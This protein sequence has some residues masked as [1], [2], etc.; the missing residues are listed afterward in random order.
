MT[1]VSF[2]F[3]KKDKEK[4]ADIARA[5]KGIERGGGWHLD[6][7]NPCDC[8]DSLCTGCSW[9][10]PVTEEDGNGPGEAQGYDSFRAIPLEANILDLVKP[11]R[12]SWRRGEYIIDSGPSHV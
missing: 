11:P 6:Q 9:E 1:C 8:W 2:R 7:A 10:A 5:I 12:R 3:L 4:R